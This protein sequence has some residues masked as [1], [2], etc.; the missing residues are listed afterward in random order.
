VYDI[1]R[2]PIHLDTEALSCPVQNAKATLNDFLCSVAQTLDDTDF[3]NRTHIDE[4]RP[5]K[6]HIISALAT[7][8]VANWE[9]TPAN[10]YFAQHSRFRDDFIEQLGTSQYHLP[11]ILHKW[12]AY[13]ELIALRMGDRRLFLTY[14]G[15][16]GV[17]PA[18]VR[19]GDVVCIL[20][21]VW[22]PFILRRQGVAAVPAQDGPPYI[23]GCYPFNEKS[24]G[25]FYGQRRRNNQRVARLHCWVTRMSTG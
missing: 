5:T 22:I 25:T 24:L 1:V 10:S 15:Y 20:S 14:S 2:A 8:L 7:A 6:E 17:C 21:N 13:V 11:E 19:A 18:N 3:F 12:P 16:I 4:Y 9:Y 23:P